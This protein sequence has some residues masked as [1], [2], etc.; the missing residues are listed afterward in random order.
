MTF[1]KITLPVLAALLLLLLSSGQARAQI[2]LQDGSTAIT[3]SATATVSKSVSVTAGASVL[4]V[5]VEA[6]NSGAIIGSLPATLAWGGQT[7]SRGIQE[8]SGAVADR[9]EAIYYLY[10]PTPGTNTISVTVTGTDATWIAAY[11]LNGVNTSINPLSGG[12][13]DN[14]NGATIAFNVAGVPAGAWAADNSIYLGAGSIPTITGTGGV[15]FQS[16]DS[17]GGPNT[18][19]TSGYLAGLSAG[20]D[21]FSAAWGATEKGDFEAL[22]FMPLASADVYVD[23]SNHLAAMPSMGLGV[24]IAIY[25][26]H[27]LDPNLPPMLKAAG[28]T[29]IRL[30]GG[31]DSDGY[32]WQNNTGIGGE[33]VYAPDTFDSL[34]NTVVIPTGAQ[35]IVTVNYGS[36][37]ANNG[38]GDPTFAAAWVDYANNTK[39]YGIKYWEI[40]NEEYGNGYFSGWNWEYD[41]HFLDQTNTDRVGQPALSPGA[42][43]TNSLPFF[44]DMKAKDSSIKCGIHILTQSDKLTTWNQ[45]LLQACGSQADFVIIHWYPGGSTAAMLGAST[46]IVPVIQQTMNQLTNILG[47]TKASQV[48]TLV[49]ETG[50]GT[51]TGVAVSL[52]AADNY[53]TWLENGA[54]TVDYWYLH[55][56]ILENDQTPGEGYFGVMMA[57]LLANVGDTMLATTSDRNLLRV[58]AAARQDGKVGVMLVNTD[59]LNTNTVTV[60]INGATLATG[61]TW[62]QFGLTNFI[63]TNDAPSFPVSTNSVTGLGNQFT[64]SVP[65]YTM[66]D[67]L[68]PPATNTP[69]VLAAISNRTVNA[70]QTVAFTASAT[71]TDSPPQ[72]LT[73]TLPRESTNAT[74]M[75]TSKHGAI[76]IGVRSSR[77]RT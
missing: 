21:T 11:T 4:V 55:H 1:L 23:V 77:R 64:I 53:L 48:Q 15:N 66:I 13:P 59:P 56:D 41:L 70:G 28:I 50:M 76:S 61:G 52:F 10:N 73:F 40:G 8:D 20:M 74:V 24:N 42:V 45:P 71:D 69:P 54:V 35:A 33:Y 25:D 14:F 43:G 46:T 22:V 72:T 2:A 3:Y 60:A 18:E 39:N 38:G 44:S 36:N 17:E 16:N 12:A 47:A 37:T 5:L 31:S 62:Y 9:A 6:H 65:P 75:Q 27:L 68:I 51:N 7:L 30:P 19:A 58:H 26:N 49:T 67:L 29:A 57:H 63:G 32:N 34:M